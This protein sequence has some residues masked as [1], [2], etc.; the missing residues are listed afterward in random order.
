MSALHDPLGAGA[1]VYAL[2]LDDPAQSGRQLTLLVDAAPLHAPLVAGLRA[3]LDRMPGNA[4]LPLLDLA[5]PA[6]KLYSAPQR[7]E[8]L[9]AVAQLIDS[10]QRVT[11][12]EF[13]LQTI[14]ERRLATVAGRMI[15]VRYSGLAFLAQECGLLTS[16]VA[17]AASNVADA[18]YGA[19]AT[20]SALQEK[21]AA[22]FSQ[23]PDVS[24]AASGF[25]RAA[26]MAT[27]Q[28]L[29]ALS[30]R[31]ASTIRF[32]DVRQALERC[33]Q[34]APLAKPALIKLLVGAASSHSPL[35]LPVADLLSAICTA[36]DAPMPPSVLACYSGFAWREEPLV[37]DGNGT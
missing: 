3:L 11:L 26:V 9:A 21:A 17:N 35:P 8:F 18:A 27:G 4:R 37:S 1:L 15:P 7:R 30:F 25:A 2:L 16:L 14:L 10:D 12:E 31:P 20:V 19:R 22:G 13:V 32:D 28:G 29:P 23:L 33:N 6:L 36:I 34:L 24:T 5:M